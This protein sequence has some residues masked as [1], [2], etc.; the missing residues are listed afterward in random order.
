MHPL[1]SHESELRGTWAMIDGV[2]RADDVAERIDW[3]LQNVLSHVA[4]D[5]SGWVHL[6][7][8]PTSGRYWELSYPH[9]EMH[10]GGP[11]S[12]RLVG[13]SEARE[14]YGPLD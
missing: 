13:R 8:D 3:L 5:E 7:V 12:L 11:P 1:Q 4:S 10:G 14:T 2:L 9:G 6:Y